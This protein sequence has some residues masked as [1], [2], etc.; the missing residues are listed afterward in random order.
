[1]CFVD[2]SVN[3]PEEGCGLSLQGSMR[4]RPYVDCGCLLELSTEFIYVFD[5]LFT[6]SVCNVCVDDGLVAGY[7]IPYDCRIVLVEECIDGGVIVIVNLL[8]SLAVFLHEIRGS[9]CGLFVGFHILVLGH[10]V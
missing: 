6:L 7:L 5:C 8:S 2:G 3:R 1:M 4:R 10:L 9:S